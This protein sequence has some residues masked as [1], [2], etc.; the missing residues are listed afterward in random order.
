MRSF[1][2]SILVQPDGKLVFGGLILKPGSPDSSDYVLVR[3]LGD[4]V[5]PPAEPD[6]ALTIGDSP[7]P[8]TTGGTLTYVVQ[9]VNE[10]NATA[11]DVMLSATLP[12]IG[13][14]S[15]TTTAGSCRKAGSRLTCALG[16]LSPA[17]SVTVTIAGS[18]PRKTGTLTLGASAT[19]VGEVDLSDNSAVEE[20][21]V[22]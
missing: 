7:D 18:A 11:L 10:G 12:K 9:I 21:T 4:P 2:T 6:V 1:G 15:I 19:T 16:S 5:L 13:R 17:T 8:V 20:T 14:V 3:Y 22:T